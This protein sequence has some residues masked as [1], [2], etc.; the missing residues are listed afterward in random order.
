MHVTHHGMF[1][2]EVDA[3]LVWV[4]ANLDRIVDAPGYVSRMRLNQSICAYLLTGTS[5]LRSLV[6]VGRIFKSNGG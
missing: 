4:D 6:D 1:D 3:F 5:M 2:T